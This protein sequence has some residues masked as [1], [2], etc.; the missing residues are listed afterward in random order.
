MKIQ[1]MFVDDI[2]RKING[3]IKVDQDADDVLIQELNEYV[4]TKELK[5][6]F[7]SF[8]SYY[9]NAFRE[10]TADVGVWISGFFGSG[11]SHFLKMLSYIL[12]NRSVAGVPTVERFRKKFEDDPATFKLVDDSTKCQTETILFNI[13]IEG[14]INK[15]KTAILRVFAK[16]FYNHL[17]FRGEDLK[18]AKLE[19][20]IEKRGKT[21][22]FRRVFESKNGDS[23]IATR[24]AFAFFED[25]VVETLIEVLG[26]SETAARNWFNGSESTE[27]SIA[28]LV[29]EIKDY[30]NTKPDDFRLLFMVDEVGQY[31]GAD[32]DLLLNLQSLLEKIGSECG[33]K[34]WVVCTGQEAIDEIIK[35]RQDEFSRIQA[36]FKTRLSLSSSAVDE[37]IQKRILSKKPEAAQMLEQVYDEND[38]VLRNL[39]SFVDSRLDIKGYS[40][41]TE[42][43]E[44]FPFVPYQFIIMQK[45]FSEVRKHGN[46]GKHF[47]GAER[48]MLS[49]F[50]EAAQK[51]Q[52]RDEYA[53]V[54]LFRFYDTV[55]GFLDSTI[56]RVIERCIKAA[57]DGN[58]IEPYDVEVLKLLY[59]VRYV[60]DIKASIDNIVILMADDIRVDKISLREKVTASLG[61]LE[62]Q[63]YIGRAGDA[64]NF[65]TDEEQ[66]IAR[67][68]KNTN[69]D[70]ASI[71]ERIAHM[72]FGDIYTAKKYRYGK[73]D[74]PFTQVVDSTTVGSVASDMRLRFLTVATDFSGRQEYRL[75]I[76]SNACAIVVLAETPYYEFLENAMKIR[77][78]VKQRNLAYLAKSVQDII[79]A[80][81]D[82]AAKYELLAKEK[83]EEAIVR[84]TFYVAGE[85]IE[86]KSGSAVSKIDQALEYL[87]TH[88][89][90]ELNLIATNAESDA[91]IVAILTGSGQQQL[92]GMEGNQDAAAKMEEYLE[93]QD[94]KNLPTSMADIQ[95]RYQGMPYGWKEIDIAAVA[96]LLI[97]Q[98]KVTI[99]YGGET[100]QPSDRRLPD[101]L[102]KKSEI[103]KVSIF[104]RQIVSASTMKAVRNILHEYFDVMDVP[105]DEDGLVAYIVMRFSDQKAHYENLL[106]RYDGRTYPDRGK[107]SDAIRLMQDV[108]SQQ[109]DN[110]SLVKRVLDDEGKLFD[111]KE[112]LQGVESFFAT[113]V[114]VFD[115]AVRM[116]EDLSNDLTYLECEAD[117]NEAL[118]EIR[119]ITSEQ[120]DSCMVYRRIPELNGLMATVKASHDKLLADKREE[121]LEIVRQCMEEIHT[122]AGNGANSKAIVQNS[123]EFFTQCKQRIAELQS[124]ALLDGLVSQM[125]SRKNV[126]VE[127]LE[128]IN[129]PK[130]ITPPKQVPKNYIKT[131]Y[132]Q[133]AF[134]AKTLESEADVDAYVERV[135]ANLKALLKG[136]DGI[137][138][139]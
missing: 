97:H 132:R 52:D 125:W 136:C 133:T 82:E 129:R 26:M 81:Q 1:N 35:T 68:I 106:K 72:I 71:V 32:T 9:S 77:K 64:Y 112:D 25:D 110:I 60:D 94:R 27:M 121:L 78:Y 126:S 11:K 69:V 47:S 15:D 95:N 76:D 75:M 123:D 138:I 83:L 120:T 66:E 13:D 33:E 80:Q 56:R 134:P 128:I 137:R 116:V 12:E 92:S 88:V 70:T 19:Q 16:M 46:A 124:L 6:H 99:K 49:G 30:V 139:N 2:N 39:F 36:R 113:Q 53:L 43:A 22:E 111:S 10:S 105:K 31:V 89:Y 23:W 44:N 8:F 18:L 51:I 91:D 45:V 131:V 17:G 130:P 3:V 115:A 65:L 135:R 102:R 118:E 24:D 107:V 14:S 114:T 63:N 5:K 74:F 42:F 104:K 7:V 58:G 28:Q 73:Y 101:M 93:M 59:L 117:A 21:E 108:L 38:P 90:S 29:S 55:H 98:Q 122:T 4:I 119:R 41:A 57:E 54:P 50:Q 37:V 85:R 62:S 67:G 34:V 86:V 103:G 48:S 40:G 96:A 20:F 84:A 79:R 109:K 100:I 87:V 127:K 61:R